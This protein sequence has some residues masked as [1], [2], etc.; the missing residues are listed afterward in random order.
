VDISRR[1]FVAVVAGAVAAR[2]QTASPRIRVGCQTRAYGVPIKDREQLLSVLDDLVATGYEGFETNFASLESSF[3]DPAPMRAEFEKRHINLIGLHGTLNFTNPANLEKERAQFDRLAKAS[4]GLGAELLILSSNGVPR[5]SEGRLDSAALKLRCDE[6]NHAGAACRALG[7]RLATH[8]HAKEVAN[9]G[10]E[11]NAVMERTEPRNVS[12]LMDASYVH[13]AHLNVPAFIRK[14]YGRTAG[15][16]V[17]DQ[18]D[19]K[20]VDMGKGELDFRGIAEALRDTRW[21]GW[22]ILEV[23]KRPDMSSRELVESSRKFMRDVM[24]I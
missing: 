14:Y 9:D 15:I 18:Q 12:M 17:R 10:E 2:A 7:L 6:L 24:K 3:D 1:H 8:N 21:S 5:D 4:K 23:N 19:G 16:H 13:N 22:V 20:Q 11:V